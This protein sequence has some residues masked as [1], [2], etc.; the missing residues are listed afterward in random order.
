MIHYSIPVKISDFKL[1]TDDNNKT[2]P[3]KKSRYNA[4]KGLAVNILPS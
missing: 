3:I 2:C 4:K 1:L